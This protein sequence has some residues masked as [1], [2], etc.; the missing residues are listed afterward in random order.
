MELRTPR[1]V[2]HDFQVSDWRAVHT[3][4][5]D[6]I[7]IQFMPLDPPTEEDVH[8]WVQGWITQAQDEPRTSYDL[9][10]VLAQTQ[11][12]MGWC[13]IAWRMDEVRQAELAYMLAQTYWGQGLATELA[14]SLVRFG[15]TTLQ[16][17]RI[18]ATARPANVGSWRVL[19]KLGMRREGHLRQ[20]RWMKGTWH[21]SFLYAILEQEWTDQ[22]RTT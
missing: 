15:F 21:D 7:V 19:E 3:F 17:H 8:A 1:L 13:R 22:E 14:Q 12:V 9:A 16:A 10:V 6:P 2:L 4:T 20:H 11:Q 18:F 5:T